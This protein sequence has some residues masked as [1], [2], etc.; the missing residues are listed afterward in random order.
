[1]QS[2]FNQRASLNEENAQ[3][4]MAQIV[5]FGVNKVVIP[6]DDELVVSPFYQALNASLACKDLTSSWIVCSD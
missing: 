5:A 2:A 3:K 4:L 6:A 1:M